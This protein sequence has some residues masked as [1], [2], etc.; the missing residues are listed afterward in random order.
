MRKKRDLPS[1]RMIEHPVRFTRNQ[2]ARLRH[3]QRQHDGKSFAAAVRDI[4]NAGLK[5]TGV[6]ERIEPC[7]N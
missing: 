6:P 7:E 4:L 2:Q 1:Y 3:Y 5:V